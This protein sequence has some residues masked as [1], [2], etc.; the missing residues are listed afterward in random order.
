MEA[1]FQIVGCVLSSKPAA[2]RIDEFVAQVRR[3]RAVVTDKS[4]QGATFVRFSAADA[5]LV[6][7]ACQAVLSQAPSS[8]RFGFASGIGE[9]FPARF[10]V[11]DT[12]SRQRRPP[13][14]EEDCSET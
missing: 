8:L 5:G 9:P 1:L 12:L 6:T 10:K 2:E 4:A 11:H 7:L 14:P 3:A 13:V